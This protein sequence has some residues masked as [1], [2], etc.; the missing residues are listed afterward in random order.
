MKAL[1]LLVVICL[2]SLSSSEET[3]QN[4]ETPLVGGWSNCD[5]NSPEIQKV[6]KFAVEAVNAQINSMFKF[7]FLKVE[8]CA[9]QVVA[10]MK[11]ELYIAAERKGENKVNQ[12]V[13]WDRFGEMVLL[14]TDMWPHH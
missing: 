5:V 4:N 13:V 6:A 8:K 14:D 10:G 9:Q 7:Q 11:Y 3:P 12:Y 2:V 1:C